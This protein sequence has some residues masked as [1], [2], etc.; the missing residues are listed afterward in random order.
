MKKIEEQKRLQRKEKERET[1]GERDRESWSER[2]SCMIDELI[3]K[4]N[5]HV[6][7]GV[8]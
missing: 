6:H 5:N 8:V 4:E 2:D 1:E 7:A 3:K